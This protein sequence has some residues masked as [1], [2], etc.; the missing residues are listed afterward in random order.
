MHSYISESIVSVTQTFRP[1]AYLD[2]GS[3]SIILQLIIA[4]AAG[5]AYTL[6]VQI[7]RF[8]RLISGKSKK[9]N[10]DKNENGESSK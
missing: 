6:R 5:V 10:T 9:G 8:F 1:L 3:G 4:A 7:A 2:P